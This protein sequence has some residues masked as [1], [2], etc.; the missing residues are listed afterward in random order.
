LL[1]PTEG[2]EIAS[3]QIDGSLRAIRAM[4]QD[5]IGGGIRRISANSGLNKRPALALI[6]RTL[7]R[8]GRTTRTR[9]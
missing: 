4:C 1:T 5:T 8:N 3:R 2:L 6:A 9:F 7:R